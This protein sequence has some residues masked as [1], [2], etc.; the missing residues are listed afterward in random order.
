[1]AWHCE[2]HCGQIFMRP[3][4]AERA[5]SLKIPQGPSLRFDR[6]GRSICACQ[7]RDLESVLALGLVRGSVAVDKARAER[8]LR[9]LKR[10]EAEF[11]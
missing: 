2:E 11:G 5:P 8:V 7:E 4:A 3:T 10:R 6:D 9:D 1:M